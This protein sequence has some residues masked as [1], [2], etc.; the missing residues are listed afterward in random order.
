M[1]NICNNPKNDNERKYNDELV[2]MNSKYEKKIIRLN[3][4]IEELKNRIQALYLEL[5][6]L[7]RNNLKFN[8]N[9]NNNIK[10]L[11]MI[12]IVQKYFD[13][14]SIFDKRTFFNIL[15]GKKGIKMNITNNSQSSFFKNK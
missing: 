14:H 8:K 3:Q 2:E 9:Q 13:K 12:L 4:I 15:I 7:Q 10:I 6:N 11:L 1:V 5:S